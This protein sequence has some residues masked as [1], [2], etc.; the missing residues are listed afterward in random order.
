MTPPAAPIG[1]SDLHAY[2]DGRLAPER[3]A[4]VD[5]HLAANPAERFRLEAYAAQTKA[6]R[7]RLDAELEEPP[8]PALLAAAARPPA[9]WLATAAAVL[10]VLGGAAGWTLH[11]AL[12]PTYRG[13]FALEAAVAHEVFSAEQRHPVEV[14][15]G[16][17]EHLVAWLS[18]R[19]AS[20]VP[21]PDLSSIGFMLVGGRL[22]ST[23]HGPAAQ[24]MYENAG[25]ERL[26]LFYRTDVRDEAD[27]AWRFAE[28]GDAV[29]YY[30]I[31]GGKGF[32]VTA[33]IDRDKLVAAGDLA[34]TW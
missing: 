24:L 3:R 14:T 18:K 15:A 20:P 8:P 34:S 2:V 29:V 31:Q 9:R 11:S 25:G 22:L 21:A 16:E 6:L 5:A 33:T 32:A 13:S 27:T 4:E 19:L 7:E 1:E 17:R 23:D 30:W 10:L 26:T 28:R 12:P